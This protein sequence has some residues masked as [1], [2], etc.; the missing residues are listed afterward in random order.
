MILAKEKR[1]VTEDLIWTT[2]YVDG[3]IIPMAINNAASG[4]VSVL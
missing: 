3:V 4:V 2:V 1:Q